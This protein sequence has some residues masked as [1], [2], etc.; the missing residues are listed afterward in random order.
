[1]NPTIRQELMH[2][3]IRGILSFFVL[4]VTFYDSVWLH[5]R[6]CHEYSLDSAGIARLLEHGQEFITINKNLSGNS[7][8]TFFFKNLKN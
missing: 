8:R 6:S 4:F 7:A 2:F 3:R 1:M 5:V